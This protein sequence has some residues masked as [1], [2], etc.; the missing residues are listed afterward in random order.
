[1]IE[2]PREFE[3]EKID[4]K[5]IIERCLDLLAPK[6]SKREI[7]LTNNLDHEMDYTVTGNIF[8]VEEIF[9]NIIDNGINYNR[10][11]GALSITGTETP[12]SMV[13]KISDTGV[14]IPPEFKD[15]IFERFYRVDKSRSRATGG[16]G[17]GLSIVKHAA[18]ILAWD[19]TV[20]SDSNGS[21]FTITA[22][23]AINL[24]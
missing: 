15:R 4:L 9:F 18:M 2:S 7:T 14:G 10:D 17:L 1:M 13:I 5:I 21:V 24:P 22:K 8:L 19:I 23:K 16:T 12:D 6:I 11:R 3:R 20:D